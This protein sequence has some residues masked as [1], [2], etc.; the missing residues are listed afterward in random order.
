MQY[1]S[2]V[3][4]LPVASHGDGRFFACVW[5]RYFTHVLILSNITY[6]QRILYN[7]NHVLHSLLPHL[8]ATGHYLRHRRHDR[9]WMFAD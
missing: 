1:C 8:N 5:R 7:P 9:D 3:F 2:T 4:R 6:H